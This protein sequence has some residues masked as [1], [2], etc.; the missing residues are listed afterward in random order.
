MAI[1][2]ILLASFGTLFEMIAARNQGGCGR[3]PKREDTFPF[4]RFARQAEAHHV[5][6]GASKAG[7]MHNRWRLQKRKQEIKKFLAVPGGLYKTAQLPPQIF[8]FPHQL[9]SSFAMQ[10]STVAIFAAAASAVSASA[11]VTSVTDFS[12]TLVTITDCGSEVTDC[13]AHQPS[14]VANVSTYEGAAN[15]QFAAGAVALAAGALLA[16]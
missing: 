6:A 9:T 11:N 7:L 13:P 10:F 14:T 5:Q 3:D 2:R 16:L 4:R 15:K 1:W 12:S 8:F